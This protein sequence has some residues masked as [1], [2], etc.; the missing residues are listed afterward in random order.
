[1]HKVLIVIEKKPSGFHQDS[2]NIQ[3]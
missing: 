1:M 3:F 2:S